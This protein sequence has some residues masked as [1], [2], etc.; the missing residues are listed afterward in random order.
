[1]VRGRVDTFEKVESNFDLSFVSTSDET[2]R[3]VER[4]LIAR[5]AR[6]KLFS[7][8]ALEML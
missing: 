6:R 1:M 8:Q 4:R 5:S 3:V 2:P 7:V